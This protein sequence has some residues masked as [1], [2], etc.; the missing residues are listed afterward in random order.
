MR[1]VSQ[2]VFYEG[3][4][5]GLGIVMDITDIPETKKK[6]E[7]FAIMDSLTEMSNRYNMN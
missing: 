3:S 2:T 4:Y 1:V 5:A 7:L 6:L